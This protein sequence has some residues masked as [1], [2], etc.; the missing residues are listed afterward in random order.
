MILQKMVAKE[1]F[2]EN[3]GEHFSTIP[4]LNDDD[5]WAKTVAEWINNWAK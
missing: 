4:C 2:E 5:N 3:G 1:S